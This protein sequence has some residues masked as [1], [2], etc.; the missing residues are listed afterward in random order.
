MSRVSIDIS[1]SRKVGSRPQRKEFCNACSYNDPS[2]NCKRNMD[3]KW[4]GEL[5]MATRADVRS[6]MNEMANEKRRYN[7]K[8][9][10]RGGQRR[11]EA[12]CQASKAHT[13]TKS[14]VATSSNANK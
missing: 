11:S 7:H 8:D 14:R 12:T 13:I 6:I 9:R 10:D 3:W 2:N 4:R 5:Y 1:G